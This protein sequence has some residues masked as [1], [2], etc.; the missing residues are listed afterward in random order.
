MQHVVH[1]LPGDTRQNSTHGLK[2][3]VRTRVRMRVHRLQ[4][5]DPGASH[6]QVGESQPACV[7]HS[8]GHAQ[9]MAHILELVK[10]LS[11]IETPAV[12]AG[13]LRSVGADH[14]TQQLRTVL[15]QA[16]KPGADSGRPHRPRR[17]ATGSAEH[18]VHQE[19]QV[20][21]PEF[22]LPSTNAACERGVGFAQITDRGVAQWLSSRAIRRP[23]SPASAA[24]PARIVLM[25]APAPE[26]S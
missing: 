4:N 12:A 20:E 2:D 9:T 14:A 18:R 13:A 11:Q 24:P 15:E 23:T 7:I 8:R 25:N 3:R 1:S 26:N 17:A 22:V 6:P 10:I 16:R 5:R 19:Y 21:V